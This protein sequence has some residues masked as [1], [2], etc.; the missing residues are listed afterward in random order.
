MFPSGRRIDRVTALFVSLL[1]VSFIIAT[2]DVRADGQGAGTLFR[3]GAQLLFTP[4]QKAIDYVT[5]PIVGFV[6]GVA[7]V[8]GLRDENERLQERVHEL[9]AQLS[10]TEA[11]ERRVAELEAINGLEPPR[12]IPTVT[13]Q[14]YAAGAS[15]F[16]Q[17]RYINKG[18]SDG[19]VEGQAVIDEDGL[20]GRVD[21]VTGH[22]ARVRLITDPLVSVGVRVQDTNETGIATG[23]GSGPLRLSM[24]RATETVPAGALVMTDG[25]RFPPG[26]VVGYVTES[27]DIEVNF[28]LRTAVDPAARMGQLDFVKVVIGWSPLDADV[29]DT[30]GRLEPPPVIDQEFIE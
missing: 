16:D 24:F 15:A 26:I 1:A 17:L 27:A 7:D 29:E 30:D 4:V 10:E 8:A 18:S 23:Q 9:Q 11:M 6:D 5:R 14:I 25:S 13:A 19:V 20:V 21:L 2:F 22:N 28:A 3:D 12:D